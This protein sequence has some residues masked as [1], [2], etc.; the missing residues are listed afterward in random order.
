MFSPYRRLRAWP[1]QPLPLRSG[2]S[3]PNKIIY[4]FILILLTIACFVFA[5]LLGRCD[6]MLSDADLVQKLVEAS[7]YGPTIFPVVYALVVGGALRS[8]ALWRLQDGEKVSFLDLLLGSTSVGGMVGTQL[9]RRLTQFDIPSLCLMFIWAL[10]PLGGQA[11]FRIITYR[12]IQIP[13]NLTL[14]FLDF[15]NASSPNSLSSVDVINL[16]DVIDSSFVSSLVS[17]ASISQSPMDPWG[18]IKIPFIENLP[19]YDSAG[20]DEWIQFSGYSEATPYS[21]LVGIPIANIPK[22]GDTEFTIEASYWNFR[23]PDFGFPEH[24][25]DDYWYQAI[26][27]ASAG[28]T[29]SNLQCTIFNSSISLPDGLVTEGARTP[30][31]WIMSLTRDDERERRCAAGPTDNA[32]ARR[33]FFRTRNTGAHKPT[34]ANCT[35]GTTN[36]EASVNCKGWDCKVDRLRRSQKRKIYQSPAYTI[37]DHCGDWDSPLN[38]PNF[39][40]YLLDA[41]GSDVSH[42]IGPGLF[43]NY[44][45]S[46]DTPFARTALHSYNI[47]SDITTIGNESFAVRFSQILNSYW[48]SFYNFN[49]TYGGHPEN[50]AFSTDFYTGYPIWTPLA[51]SSGINTH[52]ETHFFYNRGWMAVLVISIMAMFISAIVKAI[53]D[54]RIWIPDLL[55]N[56]STMIRGS[57]SNCPSV[58]FGGTTLDDSERSRL[59][60]NLRVR[61]GNIRT[62]DGSPGELGI[63]ELAEGEGKATRVT[64]NEAYW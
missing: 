8:L 20:E 58:P 48:T 45:L 61:Y 35:M 19:G 22:I 37:F 7:R 29:L 41:A 5:G 50:L 63:G 40:N 17:P 14:S 1:E 33:L 31:S 18:N 21:S 15:S 64:Q 24:Y 26:N 62:Q 2:V 12:D 10:S 55:M 51:E 38:L 4:N 13:H 60:K 16:L 46:P 23:C 30:S 52:T 28:C 39:L 11:S 25:D 42:S 44:L 34:A 54:L 53:F 3:R 59:L 56:V 9:E 43:Q 6:G 49:L 32:P 57:A 27:N 36:V 47:D